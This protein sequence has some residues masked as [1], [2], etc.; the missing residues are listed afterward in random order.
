MQFDSRKTPKMAAT[1]VDTKDKKPLFYWTVFL[2][3]N[4][5][6]K[7]TNSGLGAIATFH[8]APTFVKTWSSDQFRWM[9]GF[10]ESVFNIAKAATFITGGK[11][12]AWHS[13]TIDHI[14]H[15]GTTPH[16][17]VKPDGKEYKYAVSYS[18]LSNNGA[19]INDT[20]VMTVKSALEPGT[21]EFI[22][23]VYDKVIGE[24]R[25]GNC[26]AIKQIT[27]IA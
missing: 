20:V 3:L 2:T 24:K 17:D 13:Y 21:N 19:I 16:Q 9:G 7:I 23:R 1:D 5:E 6:I 15:L 8:H 27:L 26:P 11:P 25:H 14:F 22:N 18:L 12:G 10:N 4:S